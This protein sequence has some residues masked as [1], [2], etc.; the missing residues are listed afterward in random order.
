MDFP[1]EYQPDEAP[2]AVRQLVNQLLPLLIEG[3][4]PALAAL[5]QQLPRLRTTRV[6]LTGSGFYVDFDVPG[7]VPL[8]EPPNFAG[9]DAVITRAGFTVPAGCVLFVR[10]GR[11]ATLEGY[12]YGE[13]WPDDAVVLSIE[14]VVPVFPGYPSNSGC[15]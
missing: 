8:A 2:E 13:S 14:D 3:D 5:R 11:L 10:K 12:T 15:T 1:K 6:E 7:E 4:H 9:G